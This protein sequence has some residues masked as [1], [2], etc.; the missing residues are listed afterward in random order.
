M[1]QVEKLE[2]PK[3]VTNPF[4]MVEAGK[5][6][7]TNS[8][9]SVESQRAMIEVLTGFEVAKRFPRDPAASM[10]MILHECTRPSLAEVAIYQFAKGGTSISGPSIRLMEAIAR[11]WGH[12][13]S[14]FRVLERRPGASTIQ[15]F[16]RDLQTNNYIER[17]FE[18]RHWRD[19]KSGGYPLKDE[20]DI[21]ELEASMAQRRVRV[22]IQGLIPGD[23]VDAAVEQCELTMESSADTTPEGIAKLCAAFAAFKVNKAMIEARIQSKLEAIKPVQVATLRKIYASLR[24]GMADAKDFFDISLGE[25]EKE[26]KTQ[27]DLAAEVKK[28]EEKKPEECLKKD[29]EHD[30]SKGDPEPEDMFPGDK[31]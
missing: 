9:T 11:S 21:M 6:A 20:R 4:Q 17:I 1:A 16:A 31:T 19:T 18:V 22:C 8:L 2:G 25:P 12:V 24:D 3:M 26:V 30:Y 28:T 15:A 14:G 7:P 10:G 23:V 29:M 27:P 5:P 13:Q